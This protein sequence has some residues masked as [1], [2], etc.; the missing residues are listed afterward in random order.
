MKDSFKIILKLGYSKTD[1]ISI[2]EFINFFL[3]IT[4]YRQL[5]EMC[6]FI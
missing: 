1:G 2:Q 4:I 5:L 3:N 6:M